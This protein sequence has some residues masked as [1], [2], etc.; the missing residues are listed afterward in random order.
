MTKVD[1][2]NTFFKKCFSNASMFEKA[3]LTSDIN[4]EITDLITKYIPNELIAIINNQQLIVKGS[5]GAGRATRTPWIAILDKDITTS[6]REG[7]YIVFL[8]SSD[9]KHVYL[10]LNQG[11]TV[12]G[13]L[14]QD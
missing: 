9:Y 6:T 13:P 8:F 2:I 3:E 12:P 4:A 14:G 10:T 5:V 11:T 1:I 7:V